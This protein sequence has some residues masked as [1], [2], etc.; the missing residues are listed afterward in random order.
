MS[1]GTETATSVQK[2]NPWGWMF[3]VIVDPVNTFTQIVSR[4]SEPHPKDPAKTKDGTKWW[5]PV[6]V[7]AIAAVAVTLWIVPNIVVP[8]QRQ[9]VSEMIFEQGGTDADVD[10]AMSVASKVALPSGI[11][12]AGIQTFLMLFVTAGVLHLLMKMLGGKGSFRNGRAVVA[13]SMIVSVIGTIVKFPIMVSK[14]TMMPELGPTLLLPDL[15]PSDRLF[16]FLYTGFDVFTIWWMIVLILGLSVG[17]RVSR[18]KSVAVVVVLWALMSVFVML[19][20][21]GPFGMQG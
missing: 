1:N 7:A 15:Q 20:P 10:R 13:Y 6:I 9:M 4:T 19:I 11:V 17:Y 21:G 8:M 14:K 18:G 12:G 5:I 16:K 3:G 2:P